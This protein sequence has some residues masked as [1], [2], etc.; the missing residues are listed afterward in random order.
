[1][2]SRRFKALRAGFGNERK[3]YQRTKAGTF[4]GTLADFYRAGLILVMACFEKF[5]NAPS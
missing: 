2:K 5:D 1:M 3:P 4:S